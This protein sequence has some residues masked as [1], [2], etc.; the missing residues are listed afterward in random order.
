ETRKEFA[1]TRKEVQEVRSEMNAVHAEMKSSKNYN[2]MAFI[3]IVVG[4][5][6]FFVA[7]ATIVSKAVGWIP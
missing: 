2:M 6:G 1:E 4:V 3:A 5:I 7:L